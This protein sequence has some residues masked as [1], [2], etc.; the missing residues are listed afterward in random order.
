MSDF[1]DSD[2]EVPQKAGNYMRFDEDENKFRILDKPIMGYEYWI[3]N[4]DGSRKPIR[5]QMD[6]DIPVEELEGDEIP[7]HFWAMPVY[8]YQ[9]EKIQIL[10]ITQKSILKSI[11]ALERS[12]DWGSPLN[13][14]I[15]VFKTGQKLETRYNVQPAP[16]KPLSKA[17]L[18]DYKDMEIDLEA[19]FEGKD[20]FGKDKFIDEVSKKIEV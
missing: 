8:N 11:R 3:T 17:L 6:E 14:D 7:K 2:Y 18:D 5:K 19:L 20:P 10:E 16:P 9:E 13:Y 1:L 12:K 15:I 4:K